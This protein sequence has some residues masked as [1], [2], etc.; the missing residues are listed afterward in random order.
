ML[1]SMIHT[2][3]LDSTPWMRYV[4]ETYFFSAEVKLESMNDRGETPVHWFPLEPENTH[5]L[6]S[7]S[8]SSGSGSDSSFDPDEANRDPEVEAEEK[9]SDVEAHPHT[10]YKSQRLWLAPGS[11][12]EALKTPSTLA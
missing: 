5:D 11:A 8:S 12:V 6:P 2:G 9:I 3:D 1:V 4:T 10:P 7:P